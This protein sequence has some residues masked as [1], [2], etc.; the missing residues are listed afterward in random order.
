MVEMRYGGDAGTVLRKLLQTSLELV[1]GCQA[2]QVHLLIGRLLEGLQHI[3]QRQ[4]QEHVPGGEKKRDRKKQEERGE[5]ERKVNES[6]PHFTEDFCTIAGKKGAGLRDEA[7]LDDA[8]KEFASDLQLPLRE[9]REKLVLFKHVPQHAHKQVLGQ[10]E[11]SQVHYW[12]NAST[13]TH[14]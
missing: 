11:R 3:A 5:R 6:C 14:T 8:S 12:V 1:Q 4:T 13:H 10:W 9:P 2:K 7:M